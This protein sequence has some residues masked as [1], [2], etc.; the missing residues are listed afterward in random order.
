[1]KSEIENDDLDKSLKLLVKTSSM[2]FMLLIMSK[3]FSYFY[4]IVIARYFG[5]EVYGLFSLSIMVMGWFIAFSS[6]GLYEGLL[7]FIPIYRGKKEK[8][9]IRYVCRLALIVSLFSSI[10]AAVLLFMLAEPIAVNLFHNFNLIIFLRIFSFVLPFFLLSNVFLSI[11][12]AYERI[13]AY[14]V[15]LDFIQ[16]FA[17]ALILI[18]LIFIGFNSNSVIISYSIGIF[19]IFILSFLY[20][21]YKIPEIF[22]KYSIKKQSKRKISNQFFSYSWPILFMSIVYS[23]FPWIDFFIIGFFKGASQVGF[24]DSAVPIAQLLVFLPPLFLRLFFPMATKQFYRKSI[25]LVKEISKQTEKWILIINLPFFLL[26]VLFPGAII[27][28]LFGPTYLVAEN[29]LRFLAVGFFFFAM[30]LIFF[31]LLSMVGKS[32][33]ILYNL[34]LTSVLNLILNIIFVPKYGITGA[35]FSTMVSYIFLFLIFLFQT[36]NYTSIVPLKRKMIPII[37]SGAIATALLLVVKQFIPPNIWTVI[38]QGI[39]FVLIYIIMIFIT[40]SLDRNDIM[41]LHAVKKKILSEK[42]WRFG[43]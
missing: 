40:K 27:N 2:I 42:K 1:M 18:L 6:L 25:N 15:I 12:Q 23:I 10:V 26:M 38:L 9:K 20:C 7:R 36:K 29:A 16:H 43:R 11:I 3:L 24:Y 13:K 14:T 21:K 39:F 41:I 33:L 28:L 32:R 4:R 35:A 37:I 34:L 31:N 17:K 5:P 19:I 30:A 8:N 22:E